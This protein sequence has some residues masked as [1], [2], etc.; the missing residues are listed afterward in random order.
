MKRI[1]LLKQRRDIQIAMRRAKNACAKNFSTDGEHSFTNT[2]Y[3]NMVR[4]QYRRNLKASQL[5]NALR[6]TQLSSEANWDE[7]VGTKNEDGSISWKWDKNV[8]SYEQA[9]ATYGEGALYTEKGHQFTSTNGDKMI[10]GTG[11]VHQLN[12]YLG[13]AYA[14]SNANFP[15]YSKENPPIYPMQDR[16]APPTS[17]NQLDP[18]TVGQNLFGLTYPG[19]NNPLTYSGDYTYTAIPTDLSE[20]PA[21][22][23]DRR[24]DNLGVAGASGLFTDTRA[25]GAD[26]K[27]VSEELQIASNPFFPLK[28]RL[29]SGVLGIGLGLAALPKTIYKIGTSGNQYYNTAIIDIMVNYHISNEGVTNAPDKE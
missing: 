26:Y 13:G 24:Y 11:K 2:E 9:I 25:I 3:K 12:S 14:S 16:C 1:E 6:R 28:T 27:F 20:Y 21:I 29:Y 10:L 15:I 19:G 4:A 22:G 23:H 18:S 8:N 17:G 7:W 5:K